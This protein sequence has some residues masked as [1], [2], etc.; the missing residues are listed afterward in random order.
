MKA[1][2]QP[3]ERTLALAELRALAHSDPIPVDQQ[4]GDPVLFSLPPVVKAVVLAR[5]LAYWEVIEAEHPYLTTQVL[6]ER[7][8]NVV[9]NGVP[10]S[11]IP[12]LLLADEI[13]L[14][15]R[16]CLRYGTHGIHEY[17]GKFFPQLVR[18]LINIAGVPKRG[19][20]ADPMCGS[21]TSAVEAVLGD[22]QALGLDLNPLSVLMTRV[23]CSLLSVEPEFLVSAYES[24]RG[25]LLRPAGKRNGRLTYFGSLPARDQEYLSGW[26][27]EQVL[28]DLDQAARAIQ[29][30]DKR[31]RDFFWLCLSN[32]VRSISWQKDDDL[33]VRKEVRIDA[34]IDPIREFLEELGRSVRVVLAF[35]YHNKETPSGSFDIAE[36]D[37]RTLASA[38][39][40]W[41]GRI[42]TIITS[43]PYATALPYLDTDRLSLSYLGL[44]S[45]PDHRRRDQHMIGNR[46]ISEGQRL[47]YWKLFGSK[48][49]NLPRSVSALIQKVSTL[50]SQIEVGFRRRNLPGLLTKYFIDMQQVFEGITAVLRAGS[51]AYVVIGNNHTIAGGERVEIETASLLV[52]IASAVGMKCEKR[53]PM[54]MLVSRDIFKRNA[55]ASEEI[56]CF[57]T[58]A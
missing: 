44:L 1:Y 19:I 21:G 43:P 50:N 29:V 47:M 38:W 55:V 23:K 33:R 49:K 11:E 7:T 36:G 28:Q 32:I 16:R 20:V 34:E 54:E 5:H 40:R 25:Q 6:R 52:D 46:E 8:V 27:S 45:R 48:K 35:L 4:A 18:S 10:T 53:I 9:R 31:V 15:N 56:L 14:P 42:H 24:I 22:Y 3:F 2:I 17:R 26:F 30:S 37:A 51:P 41:K 58:S 12:Q 13:A 39:S 57:R